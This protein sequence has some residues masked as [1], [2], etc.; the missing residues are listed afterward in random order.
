MLV[1]G[2]VMVD[3]YLHGEVGRISPEAPVPIVRLTRR[4]ANP[5][6]AANVAMNLA[7]LGCRA[8][9]AGFTGD[10]EGR[11]ELLQM[12]GAASVDTKPLIAAPP[13]GT[14][15]K[16]RVVAGHQQMMRLDE[17]APSTLPA[18]AH[19]RLADAVLASVAQVDAVILSDYAKGTLRPELCA[20]II[21]AARARR[22]PVLVDPK[23]HD[24]ERYHGATTV[25]PNTGEL[26]L[27]LAVPANDY[28]R[29]VEGGQRLRAKLGLEFLTFTR[30]EHGIALISANGV[31]TVPAQARE[32]FDVSGAGDTVIATL[33]ASL[34]AGII[35][36]DAMRLANLAAG[37]VVG[38]AGTVPVARI[39]LQESVQAAVG[40]EPAGKIRDAASAAAQ[41]ATWRGR[42]EDVVF[43]NG[44]F[45]IL[46]A[47]HVSI[48]ERARQL[49]DRLVVGLNSDTS[50][51]RLKGPT[52]P[53][54]CEGD[55]A[56]VMA[57]LACVDLVV[58]FGEDT[59]LE[60]IN[61]LRPN[62]LVKGADYRADQVVGGDEVRSWGGRVEL[63]A[64]LP[65][66]STTATIARAQA[67][68]GAG[69][70]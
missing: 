43:T 1:V 15:V 20:K 47:G 34:A 19:Q 23:G 64:L 16:A 22:I 26:A 69:C 38:K 14:I 13:F 63:L 2:D 29:L 59:P 9:L 68:P 48:L 70:E 17:E 5:G 67:K 31:D 27:A 6:G 66:R 21:A 35:P 37:I 45:D 57:A 3:R 55:R 39:E 44:C 56:E 54:N 33:A 11:V 53:V 40:G 51:R 42:G 62:V 60:L 36:S 25:T 30:G 18:D 10:D 65:G 46:H 8:I 49:G 7:G 58:L 32:V 28:P 12:L 50:V 52:R 4:H 24:W 61:Q 41:I